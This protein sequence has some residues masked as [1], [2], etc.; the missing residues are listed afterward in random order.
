MHLSQ[1]LEISEEKGQSICSPGAFDQ[2]KP[3]LTSGT[4][5]SLLQDTAL[6]W[7][8]RVHVPSSTN[9]HPLQQKQQYLPQVTFLDYTNILAYNF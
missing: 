4:F 9:L 2:A 3:M 5:Y 1:L 6:G 7:S 8:K